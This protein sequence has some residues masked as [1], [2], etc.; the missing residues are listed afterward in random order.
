MKKFLI[1]ASVAVA[2]VT[3]A[4]VGSNIRSY[5]ADGPT[6]VA[7]ITEVEAALSMADPKPVVTKYTGKQAEDIQ[8]YMALLMG[9]A[10]EE[11]VTQVWFAFFP[12]E[13]A[14]NIGFFTDNCYVGM[15]GGVPKELVEE[16]LGIAV[17]RRS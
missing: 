2:F 14:Y 16:L 4:L 5:S 8:S 17:G 3:L 13:N 12:M 10:A 6:C 15:V 11:G 1:A 7:S 9:V